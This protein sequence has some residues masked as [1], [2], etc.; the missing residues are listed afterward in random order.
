MVYHYCTLYNK[1][2]HL[3]KYIYIYKIAK[4]IMVVL[5]FHKF[6]VFCIKQSWLY[7]L[8]ETLFIKNSSVKCI[9]ITNTYLFPKACT[10]F[11]ILC[12]P[13]LLVLYLY[14]YISSSKLCLSTS[15]FSFAPYRHLTR[16]R[17]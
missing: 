15:H 10:I 3:C 12:L 7:R 17:Q 4:C 6:S 8:A 11:Q 13:V 16:S 14:A 2:S 9:L 1:I 5:F